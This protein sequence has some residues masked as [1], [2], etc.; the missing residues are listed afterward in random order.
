VLICG[1]DPAAPLRVVRFI[2]FEVHQGSTAFW[3]PDQHWS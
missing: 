1:F 2:N 3:K